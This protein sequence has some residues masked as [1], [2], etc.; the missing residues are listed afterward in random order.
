MS[1]QLAN[2]WATLMILGTYG[3]AN[4]AVIDLQATGQA[5]TGIIHVYDVAKVDDVDLKTQRQLELVSLGPAPAEG[6]RVRLTQQMIRQRLLACGCNLSEIEFTGQ[7]VVM[8]VGPEEEVETKS[9][10][11]A[12]ES[13]LTP[14]PPVTINPTLRKRAEETVQ[15]AFHRQY[16]SAASDVGPLK[17]TV[18]FADEDIPSLLDANPQMMEFVET[19]LHWGGPQKLTAHF[20]LADGSTRVV[21]MQ[22]WLNDVPQ[23]LTVKHT[24]PRGKVIEESDLTLIAAKNG[25][26]GL[27]QP[28]HVVGQEATHDLRPGHPLQS[29]DVSSVPLI[30]TNDMVTVKVRSPGLTVSR[31]CRAT[32]NGAAGEI[33]NLVSLEN[34]S[35]KVQATVTG[36]HEAEVVISSSGDVRPEPQPAPAR[37]F[38]RRRRPT[39]TDP[40]D[41][42]SYS[43]NRNPNSYN[44][45]EGQ[46]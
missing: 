31:L 34:P 29:R 20:P 23:I 10:K 44:G 5:K 37:S 36:W 1:D 15:R 4:A 45:Q 17:L 43:N 8:V 18:E 19:G 11:Q 3:A 12:L 24:I 13:K 28:R 22:A 46:P 14:T 21:S 38:S 27:D 42:I 9:T 33:V 35:E 39:V 41:A 26:A 6:K 40:N 7:S 25:E 32:S 16:Q 2:L 30:R